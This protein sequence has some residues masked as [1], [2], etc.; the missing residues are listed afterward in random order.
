MWREST[1]VLDVTYVWVLQVV[2]VSVDAKYVGIGAQ[3]MQGV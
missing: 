2:S 1:L 3:F